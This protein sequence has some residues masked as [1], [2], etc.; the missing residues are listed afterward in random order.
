MQ[1]RKWKDHDLINSGKHSARLMREPVQKIYPYSMN[2]AVSRATIVHSEPK[3]N[4]IT[5]DIVSMF[6]QY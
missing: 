6:G 5:P 4:K 1:F 2:W 3:A